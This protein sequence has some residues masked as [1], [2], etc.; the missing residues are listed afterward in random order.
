M[1]PII[2]DH[3]PGD[4]IIAKME[5]P[6]EGYGLLG[7]DY[8][9][10]QAI[11]GNHPEHLDW[12]QYLWATPL[13]YPLGAKIGVKKEWLKREWLNPDM[14]GVCEKYIE[15]EM[16]ASTMPDEAI[17]LWYTVSGVKVKKVGDLTIA[18]LEFLP[19]IPSLNGDSYVELASVEAT[20]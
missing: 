3:K 7:I 19:N 18:E 9:P 5:Q 11:F 15:T 12:T 4:I 6:P 10:T 14:F 2:L 13:P 20:Q 17:R 1:T 16:P 8:N